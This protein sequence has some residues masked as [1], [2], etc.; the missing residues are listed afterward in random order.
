[1]ARQETSPNRATRVGEHD[2]ARKEHVADRKAMGEEH[3]A[4]EEAESRRSE[5][6]RAAVAE[7]EREMAERGARHNGE[8]RVE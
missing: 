8:G 4:A 7:H 6:E 2:E 3:A 1:V 5:A